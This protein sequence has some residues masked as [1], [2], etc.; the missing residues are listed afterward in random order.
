ME[1]MELE[2][3]EVRREHEEEKREQEV[4][5]V[6]QCMQGNNQAHTSSIHHGGHNSLTGG[7]SCRWTSIPSLAKAVRKDEEPVALQAI[8]LWTSNYDEEIDILKEYGVI[9]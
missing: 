6:V 3:E 2:G 9:T 5:R 8:E 4:E 1:K 7:C